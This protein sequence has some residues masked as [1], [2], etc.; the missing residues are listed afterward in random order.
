MCA[1]VLREGAPHAGE[2][3]TRGAVRAGACV[4]ARAHTHTH[5]RVH[6]ALCMHRMC[7]TERACVPGVLLF[8]TASSKRCPMLRLLPQVLFWAPSKQLFIT[9]AFNFALFNRSR[10]ALVGNR[11]RLREAGKQGGMHYGTM[12]TNDTVQCVRIS[13]WCMYWGMPRCS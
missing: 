7:E 4:R 9:S 8:I 5:T 12:T 11:W 1:A 2:P 6:C 3:D 10:C 13:V